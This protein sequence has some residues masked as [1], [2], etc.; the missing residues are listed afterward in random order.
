MS[1][2][3]GEFAREMESVN[4]ALAETAVLLAGLDQA[5]SARGLCRNRHSPLRTLVEQAEQS[6]A[7]VTEFLRAESR[8]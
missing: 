7:R 3:A 5:D 8:T 6:A 4:R 1:L 2:H